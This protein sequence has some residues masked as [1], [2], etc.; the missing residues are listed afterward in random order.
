MSDIL[1]FDIESW[2]HLREGIFGPDQTLTSAERKKQDAGYLPRSIDYLLRLLSQSDNSATFFILGEVFDWYPEAIQSIK[3][4]G[5]EIAYHGHNH[6]TITDPDI[7]S[8]QLDLSKKFLD[9]YQPA[10]FRAPQL[11]LR[12]DETVLLKDYG[13]R[14]S[15][16]SYGPFGVWE[17][18]GDIKEIPISTYPWR[19]NI[20]WQPVLPRPLSPGMM[21]KEFPYGS[22]I[23]ASLFGSLISS[24]LRRSQLK[25]LSSVLML[26]PWQLLI[27]PEIQRFN[28]RLK[29]LS[30][31]P[32]FIPYTFN[33]EKELS[34]LISRYSFTSFSR[35]LTIDSH[36]RF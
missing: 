32:F 15:S 6:Q 8:D 29:V 36:D 23:G 25:G 21:L 26:H 11:F 18:A 27:P 13:F 19:K 16:S 9:L 14:Y 20:I 1:T 30:S 2:V 5:H 7:L 4:E 28:F 33:R 31:H 22:G 17:T 34:R 12:E 35:Y 3:E 24:F 10:G